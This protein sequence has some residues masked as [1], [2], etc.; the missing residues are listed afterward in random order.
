MS[1]DVSVSYAGS[2][3]LNGRPTEPIDR[4]R[5]DYLRLAG[6]EL[7]CSFDLTAI[8]E[9]SDWHDRI[10]PHITRDRAE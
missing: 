3:N 4:I 9:M 2:N 10:L 7:R 8:R 6:E 5:R 1:H